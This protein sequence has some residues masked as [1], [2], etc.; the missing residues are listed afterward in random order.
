MMVQ[1]EEFGGFSEVR[2]AGYICTLFTFHF[3]SFH[4]C[5]LCC[6]SIKQLEFKTETNFP[7]GE[8]FPKVLI[9]QPETAI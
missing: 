5:I 8:E 3:I 4:F 9:L 7:T 1:N 6:L 2:L